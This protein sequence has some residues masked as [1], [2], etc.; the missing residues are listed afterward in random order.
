M[1]KYIKKTVSLLLAQLI[2]LG[3]VLGGL[4]IVSVAEASVA[5]AENNFDFAVKTAE[6]IKSNNEA[7]MLRIIGKLR[8]YTKDF[9]FSYAS[10]YVVSDDGRF[11]LQFETEKELASCLE[12]LQ[13]NPGVIYAERDMPV[14]TETLQESAEHLS[15]GVA[16]IEADIYSQSINPSSDDYVTVAIVDSGCEDIDF[17]K[18]KLVPGYDFYENNKD[19]FQDESVDSHGTFLAS[20]V[21]DCVGSLPVKI[22]PIRIIDSKTGSLINLING[23][24]YAVDNG[25]DVINLSLCAVLNNCKSLENAL[26]YA[27]EKGVTV[28]VCAG[29]AK[30]DVKNFCPS[31]CETA[32]TVASVNS[33]GFF[34]EGFSNFGNEID[35]AAPG[36][37]ISG[38]NAQGKITTLNGTSMSAA[39]VSA[40]AA[41]FRLDNPNCNSKQVRSA[42]TSTA[43]DLGISGKDDYYGWGIPK[44][45]S[46]ADSDKIYVESISF[47]QDT[48]IMSVSDKLEINPVF[49][50]SDATDKSF[51]L[52]SD[53]QCISINQNVI[54]A[55]SRG[56]AVITITSNDGLYTDR[57]EVTVKSPELKIK[58]N[59]GA[60]TINYGETLRLTAEATDQPVNTSVWWYV[61][62]IKSGKGNTFEVSPKNGNIEVTAKLVDTNG[63]FIK[64]KNGNEISDTQTVSV[65]S[66]FFQRIISFFK[67]LFNISRIVIQT[68]T[69]L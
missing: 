24:T 69:K 39:F 48:Y 43:K 57:I 19:A 11:V 26:A 40:A 44:L 28:V 65:N 62:G 27:E 64:D 12:M 38:C 66:G 47:T 41:M 29:N 13:N 68:V 2:C 10:D 32:L 20:I 6:I 60:K 49:Y 22:M 3:C 54:T 17:I 8:S 7:S 67:N 1:K 63:M 34:S 50:P 46:L 59:E 23:I 56:T 25:A 52:S 15:W 45:G 31:H 33:N 5:S 30:S 58:N 35:L 36:E 4:P 42:L 16:A 18:D 14:Y 37:G 53:S 61:D 55:L 9:D 21:A 51:S